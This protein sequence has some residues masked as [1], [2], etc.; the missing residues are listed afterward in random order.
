MTVR[1]FVMMLCVFVFVCARCGGEPMEQPSSSGRAALEE[2]KSLVEVSS[3][4]INSKLDGNRMQ[5]IRLII[6]CLR[7]TFFSKSK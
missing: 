6:A 3:L 7:E 2:R 1:L 5:Y 4:L